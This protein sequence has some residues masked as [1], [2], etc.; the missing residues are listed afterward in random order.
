MYAFEAKEK[1]LLKTENSI[2]DSKTLLHV[3]A[4]ILFFPK[5]SHGVENIAF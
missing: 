3:F 2:G 1:H 5:L 4:P